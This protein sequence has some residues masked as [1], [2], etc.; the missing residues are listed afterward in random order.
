MVFVQK[1]KSHTRQ[2]CHFVWLREDFSCVF[3]DRIPTQGTHTA[4]TK[5]YGLFLCR[6]DPSWRAVAVQPSAPAVADA[7]LEQL[8]AQPLAA[9]TV[10]A[11]EQ[12]SRPL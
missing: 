9:Q 12:I 8:A 11:P 7:E 4:T 2:Q 6:P 1:S 10:F 5:V 3:V